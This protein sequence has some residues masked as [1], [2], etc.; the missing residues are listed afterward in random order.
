MDGERCGVARL[1]HEAGVDEPLHAEI[2][3]VTYRCTTL[4][5]LVWATED[6][7]CPQSLTGEYS[8]LWHRVKI[9]SGIGS[10]I[11]C[12]SL[13]SASTVQPVLTRQEWEIQSSLVIKRV[14]L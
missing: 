7:R 12:F 2:S 10:H 5:T 13:D 14:F 1:R 11:L 4:G 3:E 8:R 9:D 6:W